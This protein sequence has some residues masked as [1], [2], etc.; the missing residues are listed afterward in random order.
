MALAIFVLS[1]TAGS[2]Q[3][4]VTLTLDAALRRAEAANLAVLA[5]NASTRAAESACC[6]CSISRMLHIVQPLY[7]LH[8]L[9][10][11]L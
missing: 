5:A 1:L 6:V 9:L 11:W 7:L 10:R 8:L 4:T 2:M 3:D